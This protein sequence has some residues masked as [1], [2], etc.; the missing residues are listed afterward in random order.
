MAQMQAECIV[1]IIHEVI[2]QVVDTLK[3]NIVQAQTQ[4]KE[5]T[6]KF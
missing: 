2:A 3:Q 5:F 1:M 6:E 4:E